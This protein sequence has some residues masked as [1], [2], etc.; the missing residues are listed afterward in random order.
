MLAALTPERPTGERRQSDVPDYLGCPEVREGRIKNQTGD[1]AARAGRAGA[2]SYAEYLSA[3]VARDVRQ[4]HTWVPRRPLCVAALH[5]KLSSRSTLHV[6]TTYI[7][8][9][10]KVYHLN[11]RLA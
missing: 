10:L 3:N 8:I 7:A 1:L 5:E 6:F 11:T 9:T 4:T 2:A